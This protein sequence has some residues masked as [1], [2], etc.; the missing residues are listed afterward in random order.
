MIPNYT[1]SYQHIVQSMCWLRVLYL[2]TLLI[3]RRSYWILIVIWKVTTWS[4]SVRTKYCLQ[5][6]KTNITERYTKYSTRYTK[7]IITKNTSRRARPARPGPE[8]HIL[9]IHIYIYIYIYVDMF[10]I[11]LVI[12]LHMFQTRPDSA[13]GKT[14]ALTDRS[15]HVLGQHIFY[16]C[17]YAH[18][19]KSVFINMHEY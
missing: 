9:Y 10:C 7:D 2:G 12:L 14:T 15:C 3:L 17:I 11:Y 8:A 18:N 13:W 4:Y 5:N 19:L 16:G 6:K 1:K